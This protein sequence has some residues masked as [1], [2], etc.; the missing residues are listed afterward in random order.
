MVGHP[1]LTGRQADTAIGPMG[2]GEVIELPV[3]CRRCGYRLEG[4][5]VSGQCPECGLSVLTSLR[6]GEL[7]F[8]TPGHRARLSRACLFI[9]YSQFGVFLAVLCLGLDGAI[10]TGLI[11]GPQG[12][13]SVLAALLALTGQVLG[14]LGWWRLATPDPATVD[15]RADRVTRA[16]I[17][18]VVVLQSVGVIWTVASSVLTGAALATEPRSAA[19]MASATGLNFAVLLGVAT[20]VAGVVVGLVCLSR[21]LA[22]LPAPWASVMASASAVA[23]PAL[24]TAMFFNSLMAL[25]IG[26]LLA[27]LVPAIFA[28][29]LRVLLRGVKSS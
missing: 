14:L 9:E 1:G 16:L 7:R 25:A 3:T 20:W 26:L 18:G 13:L 27:P 10:R 4:L 8:S 15:V 2:L 24:L 28:D 23:V 5:L 22:S 12:W 6:R 19:G 29:R 17:R 21:I 11:S